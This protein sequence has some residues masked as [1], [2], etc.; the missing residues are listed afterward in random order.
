MTNKFQ[1]RI[2][3]LF[4]ENGVMCLTES[5]TPEGVAYYYSEEQVQRLAALIVK[6]C[7]A[8]IDDVYEQAEPDHGCHDRAT[9]ATSDDIKYMFGV[10]DE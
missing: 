6:E 7:I 3:E 8:I 10:Q 5:S 1:T 9:W 2:K 4:P